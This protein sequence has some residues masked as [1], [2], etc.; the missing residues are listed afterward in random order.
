MGR[1]LSRDFVSDNAWLVLRKV[2]VVRIYN[3]ML[4]S[5][6]Q[7]VHSL[8]RYHV[9]V[10]YAVCCTWDIFENNRVQNKEIDCLLDYLVVQSIPLCTWR[11]W[12]FRGNDWVAFEVPREKSERVASEQ[13]CMSLLGGSVYRRPWTKLWVNR[14]DV[15]SG[16]LAGQTPFS[17]CP[18]TRGFMF[19]H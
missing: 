14:Y 15:G 8:P 17:D 16:F 9:Q 7:H 10:A 6:Q 18:S 3:M 5:K 12:R 2:K 1:K 11:I 19:M 13:S 4:S